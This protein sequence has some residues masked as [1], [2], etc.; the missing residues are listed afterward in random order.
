MPKDFMPD[1][2]PDQRL[3]L[4]QDHSD[5][6]EETEYYKDL[7]DEEIDIKRESVCDNSIELSKLEKELK[8]IKDGFKHQMDPLKEENKILVTELATRKALIEGTLFNIADQE[9]SIMIT[10]NE[11]GEF[12]SSR[13]LRPEEKQQKLFPLRK[14]AE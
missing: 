4:L 3:Q 7:T 11:L 13:R 9:S 12:V 6:K 14:T 5:S 8:K 2:P 1:M 10:Y